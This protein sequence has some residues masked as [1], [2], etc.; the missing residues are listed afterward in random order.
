[1]KRLSLHQIVH[2]LH[3]SVVDSLRDY[4]PDFFYSSKLRPGLFG[5]HNFG[6]NDARV[7]RSRSVISL[8]RLLV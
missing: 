8:G 5:G 1:M 4:A 6:E 7:S 2:I 3:L